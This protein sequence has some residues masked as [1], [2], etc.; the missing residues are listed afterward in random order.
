MLKYICNKYKE[1]N[2]I[3][4]YGILVIKR[5]LFERDKNNEC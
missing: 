5:K 3:N 2:S 1:R 4:E